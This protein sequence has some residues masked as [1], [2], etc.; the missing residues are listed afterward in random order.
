V[1]WRTSRWSDTSRLDLAVACAVLLLDVHPQRSVVQVSR[2]SNQGDTTTLLVEIE[3]L[4][5]LISATKNTQVGLHVGWPTGCLRERRRWSHS[6][7]D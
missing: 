1:L 5:R 3:E 2:Y 7:F 4:C 6:A